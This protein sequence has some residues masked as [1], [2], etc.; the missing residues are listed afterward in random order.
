MD[1][2][3]VNNA[4]DFLLILGQYYLSRLGE[5]FELCKAGFTPFSAKAVVGGVAGII[6][7]LGVIIFL[8][9]LLYDGFAYRS[10]RNA[11]ILLVEFVLFVLSFLR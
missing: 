9:V 7:L 2:E 5:A 1:L 11:A 10:K 8:A 4:I 3:N 6:Y